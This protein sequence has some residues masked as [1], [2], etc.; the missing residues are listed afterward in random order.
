YLETY[1]L[2]CGSISVPVGLAR[3]WG[4]NMPDGYVMPLL[5]SSPFERWRRWNT[6]FFNF[7]R[8][9]VFL[10]LAKLTQS[11]FVA[12]MITFIVSSLF[13]LASASPLN[14]TDFGGKYLA[15]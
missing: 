9:I 8:W 15:T 3:L 10:P 14:I 11:L 5:A 4:F 6:Y 1:A 7:I 13:H 2:S 12:V